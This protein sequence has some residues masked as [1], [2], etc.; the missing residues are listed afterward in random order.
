MFIYSDRSGFIFSGEELKELLR[1]MEEADNEIISRI[2]DFFEKGIEEILSNAADKAIA[3]SDGTEGHP[4][5]LGYK[6][7][8]HEQEL[9]LKNRA[10]ADFSKILDRNFRKYK[11]LGLLKKCIDGDLEPQSIFF[12]LGCSS[13]EVLRDF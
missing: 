11:E 7:L 6:I 4:G 10:A 5:L 8:W 13:R 2:S 3:V 9:L 1:R 12:C